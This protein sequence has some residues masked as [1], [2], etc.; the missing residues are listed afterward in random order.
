MVESIII[1]DWLF[2]EIGKDDIIKSGKLSRHNSIGSKW[3]WRK[4]IVNRSI[5]DESRII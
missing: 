1:M 4:T 5:K 2:I 3:C